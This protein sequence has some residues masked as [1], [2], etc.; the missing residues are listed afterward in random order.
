MRRGENFSFFGFKEALGFLT[1]I[2]W[3]EIRF[4]FKSNLKNRKKK[5]NA[6]VKNYGSFKSFDFIYIYIYIYRD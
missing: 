3:A 4:I 5:L 1:C 2:W 6:N